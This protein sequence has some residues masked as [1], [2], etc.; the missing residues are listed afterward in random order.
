[1]KKIYFRILTLLLFALFSA[2]VNVE[3][4]VLVRHP[5]FWTL[6][7]GSP[8]VSKITIVRKYRYDT[9]KE[10]PDR[11]YMSVWWA[12]DSA[13]LAWARSWTRELI[14]N[15]K[16]E[17]EI[18]EADTVQADY[19]EA[20]IYVPDI[21]KSLYSAFNSSH[22]LSNRVKTDKYGNWVKAFVDAYDLNEEWIERHIEYRGE[23]TPE[24]AAEIEYFQTIRKSRKQDPRAAMSLDER[25]MADWRNNP[26]SNILI[27]GFAFIYC[28]VLVLGGWYVVRKYRRWHAGSS[29]YNTYSILVWLV[30]AYL[31]YSLGNISSLFV[32]VSDSALF[33]VIG[34]ALVAVCFIWVLPRLNEMLIYDKA[35]G[36]WGTTVLLLLNLLATGILLYSLLDMWLWGVFAAVLAFIITGLCGIGLAFQQAWKCPECHL[37]DETSMDGVTS[38]GVEAES[39]SSSQSESD[40]D[41]DD[42]VEK[43][44][45]THRTDYYE[46][47]VYNF[48]CKACG[49][50]WKRRFRGRHIGYDEKKRIEE[51]RYSP[52]G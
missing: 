20:P 43:D 3:A 18:T 12:P 27:M 40:M 47:D 6:K 10:K 26:F 5:D 11:V 15:G 13:C 41:G 8:A 25:N 45:L 42:L 37:V 14:V 48:S 46:I 22:F 35:I 30:S 49:A 39:S 2:H 36:Y 44:T 24:T 33:Q 51:S 17:P 29:A 9:R 28:F 31:I 50:T 52:R 21:E 7:E 38:G 34:L 32:L 19:S 16:K 23:E 4:T 1:M